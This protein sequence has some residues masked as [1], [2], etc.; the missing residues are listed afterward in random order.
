M[1]FSVFFLFCCSILFSPKNQLC[2]RVCVCVR[3]REYVYSYVTVL[4]CYAREPCPTEVSKCEGKAKFLH[5][6]TSV[7]QGSLAGTHVGKWTAVVKIV[8]IFQTKYPWS[9]VNW[10]LN[11]ELGED[12]GG[13]VQLKSAAWNIKAW[14]ENQFFGCLVGLLLIC[15]T[16]A[17]LPKQ[18]SL[19]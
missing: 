14:K 18:R 9:M 5:L 2:L 3:R 8:D 12:W 19:E 1:F 6:K 10:Q 4:V 15:V 7:N 16:K 17:P 13:G 11:S